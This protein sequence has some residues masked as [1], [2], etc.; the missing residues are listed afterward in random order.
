MRENKGLFSSLFSEMFILYIDKG[1]FPN[2]LRQAV[3]TPI[4]KKDNPFIKTNYWTISL[5]PILSNLPIWYSCAKI[6]TVGNE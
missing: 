4:Y 6:K 1:V 5:L 3:I 2:G